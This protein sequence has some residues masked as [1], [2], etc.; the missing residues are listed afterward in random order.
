[1]RLL[2]D[3]CTFLWL[4][5]NSDKV[6]K[7][8]QSAFLNPDNEKFLSAA[9]AWEISMKYGL[10]RLPLPKRPDYFIAEG[11]EKSGIE[12]LPI[13]EESALFAAS[14]P[15]LHAD[16]FDRILVAQA[17]VHG[18]VLVTSDEILSQYPVRILW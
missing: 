8:V 3:T 10:G 15:R 13:D 6:T 11:R 5:L 16:P 2:L 9:S 17:L 14:L 1:M 12:S 7:K 18:M 4:G